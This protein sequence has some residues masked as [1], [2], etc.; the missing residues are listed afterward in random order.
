[1]QK[2]DF[3]RDGSLT[4]PEWKY[5]KSRKTPVVLNAW[6]RKIQDGCHF[7]DFENQTIANEI[8]DGVIYDLRGQKC[9]VIL[10][11]FILKSL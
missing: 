2:V 5:I 7:A 9:I 1:M 6:E 3:F 4:S 11:V 10:F 8:Y